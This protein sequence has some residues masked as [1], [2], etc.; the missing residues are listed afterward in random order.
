[1]CMKAAK[2]KLAKQKHAD[3]L[4]R[5]AEKVWGIFFIGSLGVPAMH[6]ITD[7]QVDNA[8]WVLLFIGAL[9]AIYLQSEAMKIYNDD[10][11][12]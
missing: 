6:W 8:Y 2:T 9:G 4:M 11:M 10:E 3:F 12:G 7:K 1:M 5:V